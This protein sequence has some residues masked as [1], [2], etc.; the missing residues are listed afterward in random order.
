MLNLIVSALN[1]LLVSMLGYIAIRTT[2]GSDKGIY[3]SYIYLGLILFVDAIIIGFGFYFY[4][5]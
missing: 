5:L 3:K 2:R 1:L 4:L